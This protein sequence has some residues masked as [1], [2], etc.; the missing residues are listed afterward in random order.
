MSSLRAEWVQ[1]D[2]RAE[3]LFRSTAYTL[4]AWPT[5]PPIQ[6]VKVKRPAL[7]TYHELP[8]DAEVKNMS[9]LPL[10]LTADA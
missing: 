3:D 1:F 9:T 6:R 4:A 8:S 7:E 2:S 10:V 5:Q